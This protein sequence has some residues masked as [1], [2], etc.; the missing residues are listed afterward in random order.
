MA[1]ITIASI[2][3]RFAT[4]L[5]A[6]S[7]W[8]ESGW[9]A[10]EP[11][12]QNPEHKRFA[13]GVLRT[14]PIQTRQRSAVTSYQVTSDI[15]IQWAFQLGAHKQVETYDD[16]LAAE[17]LLLAAA[18][19]VDRTDLHLTLTEQTRRVITEGTVAGAIRITVRHSLTTS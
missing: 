15:E 11:A 5:E 8:D 2:R 7:E 16:A 1:D 13:V 12:T 17:A 6:V 10:G 18:L 19:G 9:A 4:A 14:V 3:Q